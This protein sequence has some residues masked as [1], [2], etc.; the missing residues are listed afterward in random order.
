M[1][2]VSWCFDSGNVSAWHAAN[3]VVRLFLEFGMDVNSRVPCDV[4]KKGK[5]P[6]F[7][8]L[9]S[10]NV[11]LVKVLCNHKD[12]DLKGLIHPSLTSSN[13]EIQE[14][15]EVLLNHPNFDINETR[16]YFNM[17][18][19]HYACLNKN[20]ELVQKLCQYPNIDVNIRDYTG[21]TPL[22]IACEFYNP[23]A[24]KI[25]LQHPNT[26]VDATDFD[27][28]TASDF[29]WRHPS[30]NDKFI[31]LWRRIEYSWLVVMNSSTKIV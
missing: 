25:L 12:I 13:K 27:G 11:E 5:T 22:M 23:K 15:L 18:L 3:N 7:Y 20:S 9:F 29:I 26:N 24:V 30:S 28:N 8:V 31:K 17:T 1:L 2:T 21:R 6:L 19:L 14:S 4:D 16:T 10:K